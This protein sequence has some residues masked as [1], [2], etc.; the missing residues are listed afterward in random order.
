M[1]SP[2]CDGIP[3]V[4]E[5]IDAAA[6]EHQQAVLHHV[7]LHHA[8]R[9]AG[10]VGHGVHG[11][12]VGRSIGHER[13]HAQALHRPSAAYPARSIRYQSLSAG[14]RRR[15]RSARRVS[16]SRQRALCADG[17]NAVRSAFRQICKP[18]LDEQMVASLGLQLQ[19][20]L[21]AQREI[22]APALGPAFRRPQ[23]SAVICVKPRA[24][25]RCSMDDEL[26]AL[27]RRAAACGRRC[28]VS[29]A[30]DRLSGCFVWLP[31]D[32]RCDLVV[33]VDSSRF[34]CVGRF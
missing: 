9:R 31:D 28:R 19:S 6:L 1:K 17:A 21:R 26:D 15:R 27:A 25:L 24:Q 8:E 32:A 29:A 14:L 12:I 13:P 4:A 7:N 33:E 2:A 16:R 23:N 20:R 34:T 3:R 11:E 18:P 10:I 5:A 30:G 22:A